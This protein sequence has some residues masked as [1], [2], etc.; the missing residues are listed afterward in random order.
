MPFLFGSYF[1]AY[2]LEDGPDCEG[3]AIELLGDD[4]LLKL[5]FLVICIKSIANQLYAYYY[6][7]VLLGV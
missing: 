7:Q 2:C 5:L 4:L 3:M 1:L 6:V